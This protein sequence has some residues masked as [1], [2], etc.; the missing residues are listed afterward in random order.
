MATKLNP[1][2][3]KTLKRLRELADGVV[4]LAARKRDPYVDVPTRSLSNV[5]YNKTRRFIEMGFRQV[6]VSPGLWNWNSFYPHYARGLAN[7]Q[8]F[9]DTGKAAGAAGAITSSWG[10]NGSESLRDNNRLGYA[11]GAS[12][13]WETRARP[14]DEF[15]EIREEL[16]LAVMDL[17]AESGSGFAF[18][19]QTLYLGRDGGLDEQRSRAAEAAARA[20]REAAGPGAEA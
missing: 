5:K 9:I 17:V 15:Y 10:D 2:D 20:W 3:A 11:Y 19:S 4:E 12:V 14:I 6:F 18:P 1:R 13:S 8:A 7:V 16:W